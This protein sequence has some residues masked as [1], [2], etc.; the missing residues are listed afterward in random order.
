MLSAG[1]IRQSRDAPFPGAMRCA[2]APDE[3][4]GLACLRRVD[5]PDC[6]TKFREGATSCGGCYCA[7][8][9]PK[10]DVSDFGRSK[11]DRNRV[12]PISVVGEGMTNV[13]QTRLGEGSGPR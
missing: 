13:Q 9:P 8:S 12:D 6:I 4:Y 7:L 10:A 1:R 2:I 5:Q 3:P 11:S